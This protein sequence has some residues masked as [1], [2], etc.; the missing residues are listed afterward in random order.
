MESNFPR[1]AARRHPGRHGSGGGTRPAGEDP[2]PHARGPRR[3]SPARRHLE[4]AADSRPRRR[5]RGPGPLAAAGHGRGRTGARGRRGR[6]DRHRLQHGAPLGGG[7][8]RR[9]AGAAPAHRGRRGGGHR[10]APVPPRASA[11]WPRGA[12]SP[13]V[14]TAGASRRGFDWIAPDGRRPGGSSTRRSRG[15]GRRR[16]G[17]RAFE[18]AAAA[19]AARGADLL[20][21]GCTELPLA[22]RGACSPRTAR[23]RRTGARRGDRRLVA[24][25]CPAG[26]R[27]VS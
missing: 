22:A 6:G 26:R 7:T 8:G 19:L 1:Y 24:R 18:G 9:R 27:D 20:L 4:R 17:A 16:P 11:S 23:G 13:P 10:E 25:V 12:P 15:E 21:L 3:G 2:R 14:S 5:D